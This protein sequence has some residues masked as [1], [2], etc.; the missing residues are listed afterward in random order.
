MPIKLFCP[1]CGEVPVARR[2]VHL[3]LW[4]PDR[5]N[6]YH[7][8]CPSCRER[9]VKPAGTSVVEA[10]AQ[11]AGTRHVEGVKE[12]VPV[13]DAPPLTHDD[14]LDFHFELE[15]DDQIAAFLDL[16]ADTYGLS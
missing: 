16:N 3:E 12:S 13:A 6:L 2:H 8:D 7:F 5:P 4:K 9:V 1:R 10:L 14:L 11:E 15:S